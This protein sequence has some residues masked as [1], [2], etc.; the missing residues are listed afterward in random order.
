MRY[1]IILIWLLVILIF[2]L[3]VLFYLLILLVCPDVCLLVIV[4]GPFAVFVC[5][6]VVLVVLAFL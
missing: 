3:V 1:G 2:L 4:V 6:L 5:S